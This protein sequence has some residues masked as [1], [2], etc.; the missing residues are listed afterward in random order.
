MTYCYNDLNE[1]DRRKPAMKHTLVCLSI[2]TI[3]LASNAFASAYKWENSDNQVEYS[4]NPPDHVPATE[5]P[6]PPPSSPDVGTTEQE[7]VQGMIE[8]QKSERMNSKQQKAL[9]EAQDENAAAMAKNCEQFQ[10]YLTNLQSKE[11]VK[12]IQP[13]GSGILLSQEQRTAEIEKAKAG[14]A[15]YCTPEPHGQPQ[16]TTNVP[17]STTG[18]KSSY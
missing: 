1:D 17:P 11:R 2:I 3:S 14:V 10:T 15:K 16:S 13:D 9:Q 18:T 5:I 4:Q 12:L 6:I 7:K 8:Q